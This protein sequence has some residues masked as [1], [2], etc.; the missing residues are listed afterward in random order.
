VKRITQ[1]ALLSSVIS[2]LVSVISALVVVMGTCHSL[3]AQAQSLS[4]DER[5]HLIDRAIDLDRQYRDADQ[6]LDYRK[7]LATELEVLAIVRRV[8][9]DEHQITADCYN[10][11]GN[12]STELSDYAAARRYHEQALDIRR[13]ALGE[14]HADTAASYNNLGNALKAL[15]DYAT[16]RRYHEQSLAIKLK[17]LGEEHA[18][19]AASY[20]NLGLVSCAIGDHAAARKY[21]ERSLAIRLK[22]LG[23]QHADSADSYNN[24]GN[25]SEKLGDYS[26]ARRYYEHALTIRRKVLGEEHPRTAGSYNN[27]GLVAHDLGNF[28]DARKYHERALAI[29]RKVLGETHADTA[30]SYNNLGNVLLDLSDYHAAQKYLERALIIKRKILGEEHADTANVYNNL[31]CVSRDLGDYASARKYHEQALTIR[32]KVLGEDH[33]DTATSYDNLGNVSR[34]LGNYSGARKY[35]ELAVAIRRKVLGEEHPDTARSYDNLGA[36]L[37]VLGDFPAARKYHEHALA[38]KRKALGEEHRETAASYNFVGVVAKILGDYAVARERFEQALA[39]QRKVLGEEHPDTAASYNNLG[40]V[41]KDLGDYAAAR[42]YLLQALAIKRKVMGNENAETASSYDNLGDVSIDLGDYAGARR[43][44]EQALEIRRKAL[45][46][47]HPQTA[48]SYGQVGL[49]TEQ[50]GDYA[51]A[52][53]YY[54]HALMV[55]RKVLGEEHSSTAW[56]YDNL[57]VLETDIGDWPAAASWVERERRGVRRAVAKTLPSLSEREQ[58][59]F[60]QTS[61][62]NYFER[63][64]SLA[65]LRP[66]DT[67]IRSQ[68]AAWLLNAKGVGQQAL[69]E[70]TLLGREARDPNLAATVNQLTDVRRRLA[71]LSLAAPKPGQFEVRQKQLAEMSAQESQLAQ[72]LVEAGAVTQ[73]GE[74]WVELVAVRKAVPGGSVL[75]DIARF[76]VYRLGEKDQKKRKFGPA[77]YVAWIIP[78]IGKGDVQI[79]DLGEAEPIDTQI[80]DLHRAIQAAGSKDSALVKDGEPKAE[81]DVRRLSQALADQIW[82]P[83]APHVAQAK[84]LYL[85]PDGA[86]W[87]VPW[88]ALPVEKDKFLIEKLSINYL[89]SGR[90]VIPASQGKVTEVTKPVVFADPNFDLAPDEVTTAAKAVLRTTYQDEGEAQRTNDR[91]L[92]PRVGRLPGTAVEAEAVKPNVEKLTGIAPVVYQDM[93]ALESVAKALNRP[94]V[95]IFSTHGFFLPDQEAKPDEKSSQLALAGDEQRGV[96]LTKAGKP[97]E[98]PLLRCGLLFAGCNPRNEG[99]AG[100]GDDGVLTGMEIVGIDF[101]GTELVVLSACETGVGTVNNGEGVA[102]LRQAFQL[103]GAEAVVATLWQIPDADSARLMNDFFANLA[104]GQSKGDALRNAQL[105]RIGARREKYGAAHPYFWAAFTITGR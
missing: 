7:A 81:A 15:G 93:Y 95:A 96:P 78:P 56:S 30:T 79:V 21:H 35:Y 25:V 53:R 83:L 84:Q 64:L 48:S 39:I 31:G 77:R 71:Q 92:L 11:L 26:S 62:R 90:D 94:K 98:N 69:A 52:R 105:K 89:I 73:G 13:K 57:M 24:L 12:A 27:L 49:M 72:K 45:G 19:T 74:L 3:S 104:A 14:Q 18:D 82:K 97:F 8:F 43:Y 44:H 41:S 34:E 2:A 54:E 101:R 46:E 10:G 103:A 28:A 23:E 5:K 91:S 67:L 63:A 1:F 88:G 16:A 76:R 4:R 32:R 86:L 100:S 50:L 22:V 68:S 20:N 55:Q 33:A 102:G 42:R 61:D 58:R 80:K 70:R 66:Q 85:S 9:G 37:E 38:I 65:F 6:K 99:Q 75:I 60:L 17:V 59:Q 40:V 29:R 51:E 87:L 36:M 47:E